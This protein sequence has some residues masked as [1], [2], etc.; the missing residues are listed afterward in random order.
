MAATEQ[1]ASG[2]AFLRCNNFNQA[3]INCSHKI[4]KI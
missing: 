1:G 2:L 4:Q 3:E